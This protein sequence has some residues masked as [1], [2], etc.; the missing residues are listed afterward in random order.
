MQLRKL[1]KGLKASY[2][3]SEVSSRVQHF[4]GWSDRALARDVGAT[5][6][7]HTETVKEYYDLCGE[8]MLLSWGESLH[9]APLSPQESLEDSKTRHQRLMIAKLE[10][11]EG[12]EGGRYWLRDRRADAACRAG[13]RCEGRRGQQQ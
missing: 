9:F 3:G 10:L 6:Y 2:R 1:S 5:G 12:N 4:N 13:G 8:F 7:D 11:R